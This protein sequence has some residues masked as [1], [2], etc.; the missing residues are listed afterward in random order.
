MATLSIRFKRDSTYQRLKRLAAGSTESASAAAERLIEEGL[1]MAAHPHVVFRDGPTGR[2]A[3][4]AAGPDVAEVVAL[5]R[6]VPGRLERR[7]SAVAR[8]LTL[9][10]P[11][12]RAASRYY[13]EFTAEID[14]EIAT[15]AEAGDRELAAWEM[16]RRL[17]SG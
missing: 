10:E 4:L 11:Q 8:Q 15:N 6:E 9:T 17:L 7:A 2:R 13:A 14:D 1:R 3:G 12:V 5:L 16:E